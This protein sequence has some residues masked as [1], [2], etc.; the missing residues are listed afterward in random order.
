MEKIKISIIIAT[1]NRAH[2]IQEMIGSI[3]NQTHT[4]WECLIIDDGS[5]DNTENLILK[6]QLSESRIK[7]YKRPNSF[8]KGLP[9]CRNFGLKIA[10]AENVIFM[11]DDDIAH[12]FLLELSLKELINQKKDYCRFLRTTFSGDFSY[13][14]N[15][16]INFKITVL[17]HNVLDQMITGEIPFNS[18]QILWKKSCFYET[19]FNE[20]LMFAE[21]WE[22][23]SRIIAEGKKGISIQKELYFGRK[24]LKSNTGEFYQK[25]PIRKR[26]KIEATKL[27][28][29]NLGS[30]ELLNDK[31]KFFFIR[32]GFHLN[33][34]EIIH[35]ILVK[36]KSSR[37][38]QLKYNVG[39]R[40]Y[41]ILRPIFILKGRLEST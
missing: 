30:K 25:N 28:I 37:L 34:Y 1:F 24:H 12:P 32:L 35:L 13:S 38:E 3:L 11:D 2:F 8:K 29:Y 10:E 26:S 31:L 5:T 15:K 9:G 36:T 41:P 40:V 20:K 21:E 17:D 27:I 22:C 19:S 14:F 18:C 16:N 33:C 4:N 39:F 23:Y 6:I 7:Y